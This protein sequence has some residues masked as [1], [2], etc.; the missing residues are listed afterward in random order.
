MSTDVDTSSLDFSED[1]IK[2]AGLRPEGWYLFEIRSRKN[3]HVEAGISKRTGKPYDAFDVV[4]ANALARGRAEY[5]ET[6][7]FVR[8][9]ELRFGFPMS[10][11][12]DT[13]PAGL[14][15]LKGLHKAVTG[16]N[17]G[18]GNVESVV[19]SLIGGFFWARIYHKEGTDGQLREEMDTWRFRS[20][21]FGPPQTVAVRS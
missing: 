19:D 13:S 1:Q 11:D 6:G 3:Q 14:A 7:N 10:V 17:L 18:A 21:D 8:D 4:R 9:E 16:Q 20:R 12:L 5:D 2:T 15:R